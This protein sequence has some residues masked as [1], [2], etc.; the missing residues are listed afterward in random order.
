[1]IPGVV[2]QGPFSF[3][4]RNV[5]LDPLDAP[6]DDDWFGSAVV[7]S[8][9]DRALRPGLVAD[10]DAIF[11]G[12][13]S[14][15]WLLAPACV[16]SGDNLFGA[17]IVLRSQ[18]LSPLLHVA[19]DVFKLPAVAIP[20]VLQSGRHADD[21][22]VFAP[23]VLIHGSL[24]PGLHTAL[25]TLFAPAVAGA[26]TLLPNSVYNAADSFFTPAVRARL[27]PAL[28]VDGDALF[29]FSSGKLLAGLM[30]DGDAFAVPTIGISLATFN[31]STNAALSNG[32]LTATHTTATGSSGARVT[33]SRNSGK[34]YFEVT[35]GATHG[36]S[37]CIGLL[38]PGGNYSSIGT[39]ADMTIVYCS[40]GSGSIWAYSSNTGKNLG[41]NIIAGD[42]VGVAVDLTALKIW[43]RKNNGNWNGDAAANPATGANGISL[44]STT[45][46]PFVG[47]DGAGT[48]SGDNFTAN[49]G[50]S[51]F[52]NVAPSGY[53]NW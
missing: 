8:S 9:V 20:G 4:P 24:R 32:N 36:A 2:S 37:D 46:T 47:F 21:E 10:A 26:R 13:C 22:E 11:A 39:A 50:Q 25:D 44:P 35:V 15:V 7:L 31:T 23:A 49:F 40:F 45:W 12:A 42:V 16:L 48:A 28:V 1:M 3:L 41:G 14:R 53:G 34:R 19:A 52:A 43:F 38:I 5:G 29:A 27:A 6:D 30:T 51:A 17:T 18:I 33:T